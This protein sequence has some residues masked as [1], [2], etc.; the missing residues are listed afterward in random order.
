MQRIVAG[1]FRGR[2]LLSLPRS[3]AGVRPSSARV[4]SAIFDRLQHEVRGA[5]VLDL[6]AGSGALSIEAVSRGAASATMFEIQPVLVEFLRRQIE[7]LDLEDRV[8]VMAGDARDHLRRP[9]ARP[10]DLV[11]IDPPYAELDVYAQVVDLLAAGNWLAPD[12]VLVAEHERERGRS[13][14][15]SWPASFAVE[16]RREHGQS[17]L[18]FLRLENSHE[19]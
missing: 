2:R 11:L 12:A 3:F 16:A 5:R 13:D 10:F 1:E 7:A 17:V 15:I 4:R 6:F 14:N 19:Q 9:A 8:E 18:E